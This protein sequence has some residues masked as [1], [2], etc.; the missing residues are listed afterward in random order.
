MPTDFQRDRQALLLIAPDRLLARPPQCYQLAPRKQTGRGGRGRQHLAQA[1]A[2]G[3]GVL[4]EGGVK[5]LNEIAEAPKVVLLAH[6]SRE[7]LQ[8]AP[9]SSAHSPAP[10]RCVPSQDSF[11][12]TSACASYPFPAARVKTGAKDVTER[13][14]ARLYRPFCVLCGNPPQ[15]LQHGTR[16]NG[17]RGMNN[18]LPWPSLPASRQPAWAAPGATSCV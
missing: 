8:D 13:Q 1:A 4:R 6:G 2:Q 14:I 17:I 15:P 16:T 11:E 3:G 9:R 5:R 10:I 7:T 12:S 18:P